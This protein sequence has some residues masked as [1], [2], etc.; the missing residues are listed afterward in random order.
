MTTEFRSGM[1][2]ENGPGGKKHPDTPSLGITRSLVP[3]D[4]QG[5]GTSQ[6]WHPRHWASLRSE[7]Y[8]INSPEEVRRKCRSWRRDSDANIPA[9]LADRR[10]V[11][12]IRRVPA[13][14]AV[15]ILSQQD[16]T[17]PAR[18]QKPGMGLIP[19]LRGQDAL[20]W[21]GRQIGVWRDNLCR[22]VP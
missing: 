22:R 7:K 8:S 18:A 13:L 16:R 20:S 11:T 3:R 5:S 9:G 19:W 6:T 15:V 2:G 14:L 17:R 4:M 10:L 21:P 12:L 1:A